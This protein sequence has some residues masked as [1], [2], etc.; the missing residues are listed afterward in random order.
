MLFVIIEKNAVY[1]DFRIIK[2]CTTHSS[3]CRYSAFPLR[4]YSCRVTGA[5]VRRRDKLD[6]G[7]RVYSY[8]VHRQSRENST[9]RRS[10]WIRE[11]ELNVNA[12]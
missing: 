3:G 8:L 1:M 9:T 12:I 10:C 7:F 5:K 4:A 11:K 6:F 2:N